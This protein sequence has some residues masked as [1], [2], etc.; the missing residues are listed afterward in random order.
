MTAY[1]YCP[2]CCNHYTEESTYVSRSA[3]KYKVKLTENNWLI[4]EC[5]KCKKIFKMRVQGSILRWSD[6]TITEQHAFTRNG[7]NI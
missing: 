4:L 5:Q 6:M 3:A 1:L 2:Y 7:G